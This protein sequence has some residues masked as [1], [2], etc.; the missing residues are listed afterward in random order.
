MVRDSPSGRDA[1][2]ANQLFVLQVNNLQRSPTIA[3]R[4]STQN[5]RM[6][7]KVDFLSWKDNNLD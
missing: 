7:K 3:A 6:G 1:T 4:T 2:H 5:Y